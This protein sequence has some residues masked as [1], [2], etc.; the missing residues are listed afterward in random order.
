VTWAQPCEIRPSLETLRQTDLLNERPCLEMRA[1]VAAILR[2]RESSDASWL[3]AE[4]LRS[5]PSSVKLYGA[6]D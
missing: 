3:A 5:D 1:L 2:T 6:Y 4:V